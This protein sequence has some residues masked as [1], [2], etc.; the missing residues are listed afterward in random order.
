MGMSERDPVAAADDFRD[1]LMRKA[2]DL[3]DDVLLHL[4]SHL[5][6]QVLQD[7]QPDTRAMLMQLESAPLS[8]ALR[9]M[10]E[11][12]D[13]LLAREMTCNAIGGRNDAVAGGD[14]PQGVDTGRGAPVQSAA[15]NG[16]AVSPEVVNIVDTSDDED[17]NASAASP[18]GNAVTDTPPT[19]S[20]FSASRVGVAETCATTKLP[21]AADRTSDSFSQSEGGGARD[22]VPKRFREEAGRPAA[23]RTADGRG[24][25]KARKIPLLQERP[26]TRRSVAEQEFKCLQL[27]FFAAFDDFD[28]AQP[29]H[30]IRRD[31]R[32][33]AAEDGFS[34]VVAKIAE[35]GAS[36]GLGR[37]A[38]V[39]IDTLQEACVLERYKSKPY[40]RVRERGER[41]GFNPENRFVGNNA[42]YQNI[43]ENPTTMEYKTW[44][45]VAAFL[46]RTLQPG[47][48]FASVCVEICQRD[49][50]RDL[51][52][53][54]HVDG[55]AWMHAY[56]GMLAQVL[57]LR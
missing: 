49:S 38:Q 50:A 40:I 53:Y 6:L 39:M 33:M 14:G 13:V 10:Q 29:T 43:G 31:Q 1:A 57:R 9:E 28:P 20:A 48:V 32:T 36:Y 23:D 47:S 21:G 35:G 37:E 18:V 17:K 15:L 2:K 5:H 8:D 11:A 34:E 52:A 56:V 27:D 19:A 26:A 25:G 12:G 41:A 22:N 45:D 55:N 7:L 42:E 46:E 51:D 54:V 30:F 16:T 3:S 44:E 24:R 4:V